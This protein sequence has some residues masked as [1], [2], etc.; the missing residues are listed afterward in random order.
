MLGK[1]KNQD[2]KIQHAAGNAFKPIKPIFSDQ[3]GDFGQREISNEVNLNNNNEV[4]IDRD[5]IV[6]ASP[7]IANLPPW[8]IALVAAGAFGCSV[9]NCRRLAISYFISSVS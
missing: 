8:I 7:E 5:I 2:G 4:Y 3:I 1:D 9:I 6:L